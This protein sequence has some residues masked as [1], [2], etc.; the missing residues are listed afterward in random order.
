MNEE[1]QAQ[2]SQIP[3]GKMKSSVESE[4]AGRNSNESIGPS[5]KS[6]GNPSSK[7]KFSM[8]QSLQNK[9]H[10]KP[11]S[12]PTK[13]FESLMNQE[14]VTVADVRK[15]NRRKAKKWTQGPMFQTVV[16]VTILANALVLGLEVDHRE[17][18]NSAF[19]VLEHAFTSI[20]LFEL[21]CR[22]H[23]EGIKP[24]FSDPSSW[25]DFAL[26]TM[27]VV[28]LW[29]ITPFVSG[30]SASLR[31]MSVLRLLRLARL[32][33]LIRLFKVFKEL[34]IIAS[35]FLAG[36]KTLIW[37]G[38]F[39]VIVVYVFAIIAVERFG[40]AGECNE[41]SRMLRPKSSSGGQAATDRGDSQCDDVYDFGTL[42]DQY[43]LFGTLDRAML[44]LYVCV[45]DGCGQD[46]VHKM[47]S[48]N[49][50]V[51]IY[52]YLFV[53]ITC[54]GLVNV[55]VGLFCENV[56]ATA[57]E[58]D[59]EMAAL[60]D[61]QRKSCLEK[62]K[63]IFTEM[64]ADGSKAITRQEFMDAVKNSEV[65]A[66]CLEDLELHDDVRLFDILDVDETG[67]LTFEEFFEGARLLMNGNEAAKAKDSIGSYLLSR[68]I[69]KGVHA[70][71]DHLSTLKYQAGSP[72]ENGNTSSA[73]NG[74]PMDAAG[75]NDMNE[76]EPGSAAW[77]QLQYDK[78]HESIRQMAQT[79]NNK[80]IGLECRMGSVEHDLAQ[81][82]RHLMPGAFVS[83]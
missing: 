15:E 10:K 74:F 64:D 3:N 77:H 30:A 66:K 59:K 40:R 39:V 25:L 20:F 48:K 52:W 24:Y 9:L 35:S 80:T 23:A 17:E 32:T 28:D 18:W 76:L 38:V 26:V 79:M 81:I 75:P 7:N 5:G 49:P 33:R 71:A 34:A 57:A 29:I 19:T 44:T 54:F 2:K 46:I 83:V 14:E 67:S 4:R 82:K 6:G 45:T 8:R 63:I 78:L 69:L 21:I 16:G 1:S 41:D 12:S 65:V 27:A 60:H 37:G 72:K 70:C 43:T 50:W 73:P 47:A 58:N 13:N 62:L 56:F 61:D 53:F 51:I 68:A 11:Q 36:G 42:G 55:M 22:W 31:S